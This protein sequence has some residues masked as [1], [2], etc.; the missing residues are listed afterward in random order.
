[1]SSFLGMR[2]VVK[3][4]TLQWDD[5]LLTLDITVVASVFWILTQVAALPK[6]RGHE[7]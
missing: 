4:N 1:M 5:I 2:K 6:Y 3:K 7:S